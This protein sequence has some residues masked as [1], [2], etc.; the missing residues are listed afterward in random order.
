M[1]SKKKSTFVWIIFV[2]CAISII[3]GAIGFIK[4]L[5]MPT[6]L[7]GGILGIVLFLIGVVSLIITAIF[8]YKLYYLTPDV[9]SWT[10]IAFG[11]QT[12]STLIIGVIS[13]MNLLTFGIE[14]DLPD[15]MAAGAVSTIFI[16]TTGFI[17][18]VSLAIVIVLW[19]F[20]YKHLRKAQQENTMDFS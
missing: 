9:F 6:G 12:V 1:E 13:L 20:F 11:Y 15:E 17:T 2:L 10:N 16:M 7:Y 4:N 8:T 19:V 3:S 5:I 14:Q 18:I